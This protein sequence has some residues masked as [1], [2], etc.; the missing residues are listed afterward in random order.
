MNYYILALVI[1]LGLCWGSFLTVIIWRVDDL[2][3]IFKS[4]SHCDN[5]RQ[6][7]H[8]YDLI[9]IISYGI[10][11]GKCR[12][13]RQKI[14][15]IYPSIEALTGIIFL[16]TYIKFGISWESLLLVVLFSVLILVLGYDAIHMMVVDQFIWVAV[17]MA[18]VYQVFFGLDWSNW[19]PQLINLGIGILIG[20]AIPTLLVIFSR[21]K[22]MGEGDIGIGLIAGLVIGFPNILIN[23][24]LAF[25][26]GS[27]Y[28]ILMVAIKYKKM[29]DPIPFAPFMVIGII[30]TFFAG[31]VI[32]GWYQHLSFINF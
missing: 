11:I 5:C 7:I 18:V 10:L 28:G 9:P 23:Y 17:A 15:A 27:I 14:S 16:L 31:S 13:C 6:E 1:A 21:G 3:S 24:I 4:R 20:A 29:K 32:F 12:H 2:K 26:I 25:F 22:W 8:W 30:I 19:K